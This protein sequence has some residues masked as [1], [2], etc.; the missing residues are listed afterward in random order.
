MSF[1]KA[2]KNFYSTFPQNQISF[3]WEVGRMLVFWAF[4]MTKVACTGVVRPE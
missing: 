2:K 4:P 1:K 3:F